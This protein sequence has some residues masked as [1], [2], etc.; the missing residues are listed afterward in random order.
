MRHLPCIPS[1]PALAAALLALVSSGAGETS[2]DQWAA[3]L[4]S[5]VPAIRQKAAADL[6]A[7]GAASEAVLVELAKHPDPWLAARASRL[8]MEMRGIDTRLPWH[9]QQAAAAFDTLDENRRL[10]TLRELTARGPGRLDTLALLYERATARKPITNSET[11]NWRNLLVASLSNNYGEIRALNPAR[12]SVQTRANL[13]SCFRDYRSEMITAVYRDWRALDESIRLHLSEQAIEL[14]IN[15]LKKQATPVDWL[16]FLPRITDP[17]ALTRVARE[18]HSM[19]SADT[20]FPPADMSVNATIGY[21]IV[22]LEGSGTTKASPWYERQLK[23]FPD[24]AAKLPRRLEIL[25]AIRLE[26]SGNLVAALKI[27]LKPNTGTPAPR[28]DASDSRA[29]LQREPAD[30]TTRPHELDLLRKIGS[31]L[32]GKPDALPD[33]LPPA[34]DVR[35][36]PAMGVLLEN[37]FPMTDPGPRFPDIDVKVERF[38]RWA[39]TDEWLSAARIS[40]FHNVFQSL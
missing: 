2:V 6:A 39:K 14:E 10:E 40:L 23:R 35:S 11:P 16:E 9:L 15:F 33:G 25:E 27:L 12:L 31:A 22:L 32:A 3:G 28:T 38:D 37:F 24:L 1:L 17:R 36:L 19:T 13:I 20:E 34:P 30:L 26:K 5:D 7:G 4:G 21:L 29:E 18:I 8:L